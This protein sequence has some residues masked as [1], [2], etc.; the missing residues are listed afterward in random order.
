MNINENI[1]N[2]LHDK[3]KESF[4]N[5]EIPVAAAI[6]DKN[7]NLIC[8][9]GN[10]RQK[11]CNVLGHAEIN[12]ILEAEKIIND[13]RLDGYYMIVTLEPCD[14]CSMVIKESRLDKIYYFLP[15]KVDKDEVININ[16]ELING[17]DEYKEKF[18]KLLTTFFGNMR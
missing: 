2:L 17:Y 14:M 9:A 1:L 18:N 6:F 8:A 10:N 5:E 4:D 13:W 12:C 3:A 15:K 11:N 16:K 7:N